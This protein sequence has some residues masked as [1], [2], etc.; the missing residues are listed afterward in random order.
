MSFNGVPDWDIL[1]FNRLTAESAAHSSSLGL[2][3]IHTVSSSSATGSPAFGLGDVPD[4]APGVKGACKATGGP[5]RTPRAAPQRGKKKPQR[6]N[7]YY[8]FLN[9][10][11]LSTQRIATS[12]RAS[13]TSP[14]M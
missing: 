14:S 13:N 7:V 5:G 8:L 1:S 11:A 4:P 3:S 9:H 6:G 12:D 10:P 2:T